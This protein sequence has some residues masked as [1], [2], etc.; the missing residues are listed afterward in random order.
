MKTEL[1]DVVE[2]SRN[3]KGF[4]SDTGPHYLLGYIWAHLSDEQQN[5]IYKIFKAK[6][7]N[8]G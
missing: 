7:E 3:V 8:N 4:N 2:L 6:V 1:L 5:E